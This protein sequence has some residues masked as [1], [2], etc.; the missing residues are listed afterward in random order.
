MSYN[1]FT[2]GLQ[3]STILIITIFFL[4]TAHFLIH[5]TPVSFETNDVNKYSTRLKND[6]S[7]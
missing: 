7:P 6:K 5:T 4:L 2:K 3:P 1:N